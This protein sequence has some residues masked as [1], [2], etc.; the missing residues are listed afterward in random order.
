MADLT[1]VPTSELAQEVASRCDSLVLVTYTDRSDVEFH[2]NIRVKGPRPM[3]LGMIEETRVR[4]LS[5][6][7]GCGSNVFDGTPLPGDNRDV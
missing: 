4:L 1:L 7:V 6:Q 2:E 5:G 3:L